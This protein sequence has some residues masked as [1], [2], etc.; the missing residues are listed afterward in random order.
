M[1][2]SIKRWNIV[3]A[4]TAALTLMVWLFASRRIR[5]GSMDIRSFLKEGIYN[6]TRPSIIL[7]DEET[8]IASHRHLQ[9][10][11]TTQKPYWDTIDFGSFDPMIGV[12]NPMKGLTPNPSWSDPPYKNK[13]PNS[14][15]FYYIG[16]DD[17]MIGDNLFNWT[18][19]ENRLNDSASRK[20]HVI[21]RFFIHYPG[22]PLRI[23]KHLVGKI[24]LYQ[25]SQNDVSPDY[26]DT[27]LQLAIKQFI[28]ALGKK[29]D[30]DYRIYCIQMGIFGKW[31]EWN[32]RKTLNLFPSCL[33]CVLVF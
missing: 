24:A 5:V 1:L 33:V 19:F 26:R 28:S 20:K 23:P 10:S 9:A 7:K 4:F 2:P 16:L 17:V 8:D 15:E 18:L 31:A 3:L 6:R 29:Y 25:I 27:K 30:G 21:P 12:N 32:V 14:L 11:D 13:I 22:S